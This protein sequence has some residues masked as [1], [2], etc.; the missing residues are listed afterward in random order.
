MRAV[1]LGKDADERQWLLGRRAD[2][3]VDLIASVSH[4]VELSDQLVLDY[5]LD[6]ASESAIQ[7]RL[8]SFE[9]KPPFDLKARLIAYGS[10]PVFDA[11]V[12]VESVVMRRHMAFAYLKEMVSPPVGLS[13]SDG[14][15]KRIQAWADVESKK[16]ELIAAQGNLYRMI[17]LELQ[18]SDPGSR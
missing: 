8:D 7:R 3:Y 12:Q 13:G 16:A 14:A 17:V 2:T 4:L 6:E 11:Y 10:Q 15:A 5:S 1:K 18:R 9:D